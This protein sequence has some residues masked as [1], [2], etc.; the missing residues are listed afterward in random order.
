MVAKSEDAPAS[1]NSWFYRTLL[2]AGLMVAA[3]IALAFWLANRIVEPL[4][5]ISATTAK[6]AGGDLDAKA[7]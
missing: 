7:E 6:I 1:P 3:G 2:I 5:Q 4:R